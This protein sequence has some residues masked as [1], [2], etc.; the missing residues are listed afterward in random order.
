MTR[1]D[2]FDG[3]LTDALHELAAPH[4]PDYFDDALD[5]AVRGAQ[6][7]SWTFPERWLPMSTDARRPTLMPAFPWRTVSLLLVMLALIIAAGAVAII[8]SNP[9]LTQTPP[10]GPAAN[11]LVTYAVDGDIF[12]RDLE[13]GPARLVVAGDDFDVAPTFSRDGSQM[14]FVRLNGNPVDPADEIT[15]ESLYVAN[16]DGSSPRLLISAEIGHSFSWSVDGTQIA[17]ITSDGG[18]PVLSILNVSDG[19]AR[20]LS[21][22][23]VPLEG[24]EWR[25]PDGRELIFR[26][27]ERFARAIYAVRPDGT[28][29]R[30]ISETGPEAAFWTSAASYP[31]SPDGRT[32]MYT[33]GRNFVQIRQLNLDTGEDT[34][35]GAALPRSSSAC[36]GTYKGAP[37][38]TRS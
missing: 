37:S 22:P 26:G 20:T 18:D 11:G 34:V 7:P 5:L 10:F 1:S 6:R 19:S 27:K 38:T 28:G 33:D 23:V 15:Q 2:R 24:L 30:R 16:A 35:W 3:M 31:I 4:Y 8:G 25:P 9:P 13:S 17:A 14:A 32:L 36:T 12:V 21:L 29:F